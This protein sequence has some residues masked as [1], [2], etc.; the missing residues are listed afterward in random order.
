MDVDAAATSLKRIQVGGQL[1]AVQA[2][3]VPECTP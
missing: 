3:P 1:V 2:T